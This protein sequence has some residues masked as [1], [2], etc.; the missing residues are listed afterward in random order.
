MPVTFIVDYVI[1]MIGSGNV[2]FGDAQGGRPAVGMQLQIGD[3]PSARLI[4]NGVGSTS[5]SIPERTTLLLGPDQPLE[6]LKARLP[7]GT[8]L[9]E[10]E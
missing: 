1:H 3:D 6:E 8:A 7:S 2:A 5:R 10:V 9:R 4:V